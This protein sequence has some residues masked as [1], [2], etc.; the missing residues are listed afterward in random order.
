MPRTTTSAVLEQADEIAV[1]VCPEG[2]QALIAKGCPNPGDY[3]R[4]IQAE[5]MLSR[6]G[7]AGR[8]VSTRTDGEPSRNR[9]E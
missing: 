1:I 2:Y 7:L 8:V 6:R 5:L 9:S 4:E 3:Y